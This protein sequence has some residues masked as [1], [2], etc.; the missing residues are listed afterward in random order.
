MQDLGHG[1]E[2][3]ATVLLLLMASSVGGLLVL[4]SSYKLRGFGE[5]GHEAS[6][7]LVCMVMVAAS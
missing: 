1:S 2:E 3:K 6:I 4:V 7:L 5:V